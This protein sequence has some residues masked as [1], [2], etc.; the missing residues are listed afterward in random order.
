MISSSCSRGELDQRRPA[1]LPLRI[2]AEVR[3]RGLQRRDH[4]LLLHDLARRGDAG[5]Q[6]VGV[7]RAPVLVDVGDRP[8]FTL[9]VALMQPLPPPRMLS[10]RNISLPAKTSKPPLAKASSIA[11]VL[12]QSPEESFTPATMPGILQQALDQAERDRHLRH[13]RDVIE[14]QRSRASPTRSITSAKLR[15]RPSSDTPL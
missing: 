10:S 12:F 14:V 6:L 4:R 13:R 1:G 3:D 2:V 5:L 9:A 15:N 8:G 7:G 11:L